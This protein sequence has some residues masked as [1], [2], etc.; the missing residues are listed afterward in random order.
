MDGGFDQ[1]S[2]PGIVER[3]PSG[4]VERDLLGL[5]VE[6]TAA[7][8]ARDVGLLGELVELG[9]AV[10]GVVVRAAGLELQ[11]QEVLRVGEI[12]KQFTLM[13]QYR[14]QMG[15][16]AGD[17]SLVPNATHGRDPSENISMVGSNDYLVE[18]V[19]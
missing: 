12:R 8:A 18:E 14:S 16:S 1:H 6:P 4:I 7:R 10:L 2:R 9:A 19:H 5:L 17:E 11:A 3:K 15:D 13:V